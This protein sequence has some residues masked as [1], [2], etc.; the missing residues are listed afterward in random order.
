VIETTSTASGS[1]DCFHLPLTVAYTNERGEVTN[2]APQSTV[3][4]APEATVQDVYN[5][6]CTALQA[7]LWVKAGD[8]ADF[9]LVDVV[10]EG[11]LTVGRDKGWSRA[12]QLLVERPPF[13]KSKKDA[14]SVSFASTLSASA[15][16]ASTTS[17]LQAARP[18]TLPPKL[19]RLV[20]PLGVRGLVN[21]GNTCYLNAVLQALF[22]TPSLSALL[23]SG[24]ASKQANLVN[25]LGRKGAV[26]GALTALFRDVWS[27]NAPQAVNP[28]VF[29]RSLDGWTSLFRDAKQ[30]DAQEALAFLLDEV[31]EDTLR[32]NG[33]S[34]AT[35]VFGGA[36]STIM[37]CPQCAHSSATPER[38]STLSLELPTSTQPAATQQQ[39]QQQQHAMAFFPLRSPPRRIAVPFV[40][41]G[42]VSCAAVAAVAKVDSVVMARIRRSPGADMRIDV[43][44]SMA[45]VLPPGSEWELV[46]YER[47]DAHGPLLQVLHRQAGKPAG[48]PQL[49]SA[50]SANALRSM[51]PAACA[52]SVARMNM[53][54]DTTQ[55][56]A[57]GDD[58]VRRPD[59]IAVLVDWP[60]ELPCTQ[61]WPLPAPGAALPLQT[62]IA[63]TLQG[64][65]DH[66]L[67]DETLDE[68]NRWACP[69]CHA[70]V[71]AT[72][73][74]EVTAA[75]AWLW[76]HLKRFR[77]DGS[78]IRDAVSHGSE[79]RLGGCEYALRAVVR[80]HGPVASSGHYTTVALSSVD[81]RWRTLNDDCVS[82]PLKA[83]PADEP[84]G[85]LFLFRRLSRTSSAAPGAAAAVA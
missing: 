35:D 55:G 7:R 16:T 66:F 40:A 74:T 58:A 24:Q 30:H 44:E 84:D 50:G 71:A 39:Q 32:E 75:P 1:F 23:L 28:A 19:L 78:K 64:C 3:R 38:F 15:G 80:H 51:F 18:L 68:A 29:K 9:V 27:R 81:E 17:A 59:G 34:V 82:A 37:R 22:H 69:H 60:A 13:A 41:A 33:Q 10:R 6:L 70:L 11:H 12:T 14:K 85:F 5:E 63:P 25:P 4:F 49:V 77:A 20:L 31:H 65:V 36:L 8:Y 21:L 67:A 56:S 53:P 47:A 43:K 57:L 45:T 48:C 72:R 46:A 52:L 2:D 73:S 54:P 61:A 76:L 26:V 83:A 79:V 42:V 62:G